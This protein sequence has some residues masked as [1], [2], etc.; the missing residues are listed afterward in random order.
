MIS[1]DKNY[2]TKSGLKVVIYA[3]YPE[4]KM[5]QVQ[6]ALVYPGWVQLQSWGINGKFYDQIDKDCFL[7]LVEEEL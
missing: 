7:D 4:Q 5:E 3:I 2:R 6:G 1:I